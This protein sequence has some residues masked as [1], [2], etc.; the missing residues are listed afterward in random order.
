MISAIKGKNKNTIIV[1]AT[2]FV[3]LLLNI[4]IVKYSNFTQHFFHLFLAPIAIFY[5]FPSKRKINYAFL[6][7][8]AYGIIIA[9]VNQNP[10]VL[11]D[12]F[13]LFGANRL[14][15]KF[16]QRKAETQAK[17]QSTL[18]EAKREYDE[19]L[20]KDMHV[21]DHN[22]V[23]DIKSREIVKLYEATRKF[24]LTLKYSETLKIMFE[25]LLASLSF[26]NTEFIQINKPTHKTDIAC[27]VYDLATQKIKEEIN[28]EE[29]EK[30]ALIQH[31]IK[32][33]KYLVI[34]RKTILEKYG[35]KNDITDLIS[36][37]LIIENDLIG[38]INIENIEPSRENIDKL[39]ILS[40]QFTIELK[41][42]KLYEE[43]Q[44][45]AITDGLTGVYSRRYFARRF[46][47]EIQRSKDHNLNLTLLMVDI[48]QFKRYNDKYG[49]LIGDVVLKELAS[50]L[51]DDLRE[52]DMVCRYGGEEFTLLLPDTDKV[53]GSRA[54][55]RIR[56]RIEATSFAA[57]Q[58]ETSVT[59]SI[60]VS[61]YPSD[62]LDSEALIEASDQVLLKAK[63]EGRNRVEVF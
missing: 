17:L 22:K 20:T 50:I 63:R 60:G 54:A 15:I 34:N 39:L 9:V 43:V 28:K 59:I 46:E 56:E 2:F 10:S 19:L 55:E 24:G 11:I 61:T 8:I 31:M 47:E 62:G 21:S 3:V 57:Y 45:L 58:E 26:D 51:V 42:I 37:P 25:S 18:K 14:F 13:I 23:L 1:I 48:D 36:I 16:Y 38:I 27:I 29:A 53:G 6:G 12:M 49:H 5:Y 7:A 52:I 33:K 32:N 40:T 44:R 30:N 4:S 41:K 35:L